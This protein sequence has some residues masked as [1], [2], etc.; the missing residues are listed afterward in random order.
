[1]EKLIPVL[2]LVVA[3]LAVFIG[4]LISLVITR[5]QIASSMRVANKQIVA[6]MRQAWINE[7][8]DLLAELLSS[9]LHYCVAGFENRTEE[10]YRRIDLLQEKIGLMLNLKE[11]DHQR[12]QELIKKMINSIRDKGFADAHT[13]VAV[14]SRTVLKR[15]WDRVKEPIRLAQQSASPDGEPGH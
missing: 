2:S 15:E 10:E 11:A 13:E 3:V 6:P 8:R 7:L 12:L 9:T 14:L 4:P 5:Q 1:V